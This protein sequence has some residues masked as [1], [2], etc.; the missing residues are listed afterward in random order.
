M[1]ILERVW[2][3]RSQRAQELAAS[4]QEAAALLEFY[5]S[6][7]RF[8][9]DLAGD[10]SYQLQPH[11]SLR[12]QLSTSLA[13]TKVPA[14]LALTVQCAPKLLA[15]RAAQLQAADPI[16]W[17][18][19]LNATLRSTCPLED[20]VSSFFGRTCLQPLAEKLQLQLPKQSDTFPNT[21][22]ACA[23]YPQMAVLR[24]EGDGGRRSLICS[25]CLREWAFRRVVCPWC[26]EEDRQKLP[27]YSAEG[28]NYVRVQACDTCRRYLKTID[29]T[30]DGN[31]IPIVDEAA[32]AVLDV[33][34]TTHGY[35]KIV[36]NLLGF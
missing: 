33:W 9:G 21:C 11:S 16:E 6:V 35:T 31:A 30:I 36:T 4:Y 3:G 32:F 18:A 25:F 27:N 29:L 23:G 7:L 34:A 22:P 14:L 5:E 1:E 13:V 19:L 26:S 8:Q 15:A 20:S 24:P 28:C 10:M 17:E 2:A 12:E